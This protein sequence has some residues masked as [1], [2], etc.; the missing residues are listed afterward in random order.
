M[1]DEDEDLDDWDAVWSWR[2]VAGGEL[3]E[4]FIGDDDEGF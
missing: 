1:C 4:E 3:A 2:E